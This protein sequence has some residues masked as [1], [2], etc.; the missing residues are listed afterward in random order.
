MLLSLNLT[1]SAIFAQRGEGGKGA[2]I[3]YTFTMADTEFRSRT[4]YR[5]ATDMDDM[6]IRRQ[7]HVGD[8]HRRI[9]CVSNFL[10]VRTPLTH[11]HL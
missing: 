10:I 2:V 3:L 7:V 11:A 1:A 8:G 5:I 4:C 6:E 9:Q